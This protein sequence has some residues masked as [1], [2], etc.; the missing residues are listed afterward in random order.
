MSHTHE[1]N[2]FCER[3]SKRNVEESDDSVN[4]NL[5]TNRKSIVKS[6][7]LKKHKCICS[8]TKSMLFQLPKQNLD[9]NIVKAVSQTCDKCLEM[10]RLRIHQHQCKTG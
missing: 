5:I 8:N 3:Q 6:E 1:T 9:S 2:L 7:L 4:K 10:K